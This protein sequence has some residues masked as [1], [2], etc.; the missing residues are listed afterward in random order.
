MEKSK[1]FCCLCCGSPP[2]S[3]NVR[4]PVKAYVPGQKIPIRVDVDNQSGL[5]VNEVKLILQQVRSDRVS[6][7]L[8]FFNFKSI[9]ER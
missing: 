7:I 2:L 6:T 8:Y 9:N 4:V 5:V 1:T 3:V